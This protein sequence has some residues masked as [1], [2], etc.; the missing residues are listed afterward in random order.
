MLHI[1]HKDKYSIENKPNS[2][3]N[4]RCKQNY[5]EYVNRLINNKIKI[6][7]IH[8]KLL[9]YTKNVFNELNKVF[10]FECEKNNYK[11]NAIYY[12]TEYNGYSRSN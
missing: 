4:E 10:I 2:K 8:K 6:K 5:F 9:D 3:P 7:K 12:H 1:K 11:F